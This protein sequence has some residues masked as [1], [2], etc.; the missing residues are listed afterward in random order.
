MATPDA[1]P[2]STSTAATRGW[3]LDTAT[4]TVRVKPRRPYTPYN[5]FYLLERELVVQG[6]D[7]SVSKEKAKKKAIMEKERASAMEERKEGDIMLPQRYNN[8]V[9]LP[10]WYEPNLK[11]KRKHRKT[12][13]KISFKDLTAIISKNW[14]TI[15]PET[16]SYCTRVSEMGR[17]RYKEQITRYNA[18][19]KI[20]QLKKEHAAM[21][22]AR[23]KRIE[24][25]QQKKNP[26]SPPRPK[27]QGKRDPTTPDRII[28]QQHA[29]VVTPPN[30]GYNNRVPMFVPSDAHALA[31]AH[32]FHH[33]GP[34]PPMPPPMPHG[35]QNH[36]GMQGQHLPPPMPMYYQ[37]QYQHQHHPQ[38]SYPQAPDMIMPSNNGHNQDLKLKNN[39]QTFD[40]KSNGCGQQGRE[41]FAASPIRCGEQGRE[42]FFSNL[43]HGGGM[44]VTVDVKVSVKKEDK[45]STFENKNMDKKGIEIKSTMT[46][47]EAMRLASLMGNNATTDAIFN[48]LGGEQL[49]DTL[50]KDVP[51]FDFGD[52]HS[53]STEDGVDFGSQITGDGFFRQDGSPQD[54]DL[55]RSDLLPLEIGGDEFD[56][57]RTDFPA[58]LNY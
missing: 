15:D 55:I 11:E 56:F 3:A 33:Y 26:S 42:N 8:I 48:G 19:Q 2:K 58:Q 35:M 30:H 28:S 52:H 10:M 17:K 14:A 21:E 24:Q 6:N 7:P 5:L 40:K 37:Q 45:S 18:S 57:T 32:A 51:S 22:S 41:G 12:H 43:P 34:P 23:E 47:A 54:F 27:E 44:D 38:Y 9:M 1:A 29:P 53:L 20:L 31:H 49:N 36:H 4:A 46:H 50:L 39:G 13:G 25:F 16:K